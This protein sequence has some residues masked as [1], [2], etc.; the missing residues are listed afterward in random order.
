[1][2]ADVQELRIPA[3]ELRGASLALGSCRDMEVC[4]DG[5]AGTGKTFGALY[6]I[7]TMLSLY[8]GAKALVAR[9]SN[10]ALAGSAM[11]TY[12]AMLDEHEGVRYFGGNKV[13][14]AAFEYPNGSIMTVSGL[15]KPEK[16]RSWE[17]DIAFLNESTECT[18]EDVEF[19]RSRLRHGKLPYHQLI[20]DVNPGPPSHW[21]NVRMNKGTTTRL[22]SVHEDNPRFFDAKTQDWTEEGRN[23]IFGVLEGLTG[24]RYLR[25]RKGI[26]AAAEGLVYNE[27]NPSIHLVTREQ[28]KKW[29]VLYTDGTLNRQVIRHIIGGIDWGF[30]NP[31]CLQIHGIDSDGRNYLLAEI[32]RTQR[33]D[34]WWLSQAL[35][36]D[37]EFHVEQWIADPSQPAYI[38]KFNEAG[39]PTIGAENA[40]TPGVTAMQSR[41]QVK[42]D[43]RPRMYVYEYALRDRDEL[44]DEAHQPVWFEGEINEYVWPKAKDGQALKEVPVKVNDH[45][46]DTC[47]YVCLYIE[48][49]SVGATDTDRETVAAL[50]RYRG[51]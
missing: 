13:K 18:V 27:W 15:D 41:L 44:R 5:P 45:S 40:I 26:W 38:R 2:I 43:G 47:R 3:P 1:M 48:H 19:V 31:G 10:I 50:R 37:Q 32:Y 11:A 21:L 23:Y 8:P 4:L 14:P 29:E 17:F 6:K 51:Y 42:G 22:R 49:T 35:A 16:V 36:L 9:K 28:L 33:T 7:H 24:V 25:M 12:R 34:D 39:L 20:M 46:M 30:S